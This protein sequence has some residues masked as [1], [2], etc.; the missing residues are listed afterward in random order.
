MTIEEVNKLKHAPAIEGLS[1]LFLDRWSP[2]AFSNREVSHADLKRVFEA[3][4][5][6]PS[7]GN[8]Q[9]WRFIVGIRDSE[10][11]AKLVS[12]LAGFNKDWAPKAPV[13]ILGTTN[14]VNARG[15]ANA[16][17]MYDLGAA[18]VSITLA[19]EALGLATHQMGGYDHDA[20]RKE[21]SIPE[22][23]QLGSVMALGFQDEP[24]ALG[25]DE[26]ISRETAPRARKPLMELA[27]SA[28]DEPLALE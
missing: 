17:A 13:L 6:A 21:F 25:N 8:A 11:H 4:R 18:A 7:S 23:Y 1:P 22:S 20:A 12:T 27:F 15:A 19:A 10:T 28:W 16:Y 9:P 26:L 3:A 14:A 24:A 5:W 2:R